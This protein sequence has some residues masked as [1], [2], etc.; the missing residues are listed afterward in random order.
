MH[1]T[2]LYIP[3]YDIIVS[4]NMSIKYHIL[5]MISHI[6]CEKQTYTSFKIWLLVHVYILYEKQKQTKTKKTAFETCLSDMCLKEH[7]RIERKRTHISDVFSQQR[8]EVMASKGMR[9]RNFLFCFYLKN[10]HNQ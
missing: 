2:I 7:G 4:K 8:E 6:W 9:N 10:K 3:K 5:Y 1:T